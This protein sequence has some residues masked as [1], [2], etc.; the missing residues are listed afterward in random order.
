MHSTKPPK[1][2]EM[3]THLKRNHKEKK[4]YVQTEQMI[5]DSNLISDAYLMQAANYKDIFKFWCQGAVHLS[6]VYT[7]TFMVTGPQT[8][9]QLRNQAFM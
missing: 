2:T 7:G 1:Y 5:T 3:P 4:Y 6:S 8:W 9:K